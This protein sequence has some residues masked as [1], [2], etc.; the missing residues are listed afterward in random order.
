MTDLQA[1]QQIRVP[2]YLLCDVH[3]QVD[4]YSLIGF[5]DA[6][7]KAF[8]CLQVKTQEDFHVKFL[9]SKTTVNPDHSKTG[10]LVSS[11]VDATISQCE[12]GTKVETIPI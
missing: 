9:P 1:D 4:S 7:K 8:V 10:T 2:R 6:S 5:C 12:E 11:A 3:H